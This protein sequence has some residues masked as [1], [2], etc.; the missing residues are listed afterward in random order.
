[1]EKQKLSSILAKESQ[2]QTRSLFLQSRYT[3]GEDRKCAKTNREPTD[4]MF[5]H[6]RSR[7]WH[8]RDRGDCAIG[9]ELFLLS[10]Y[11]RVSIDKVARGRWSC[12][13]RG[14]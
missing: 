12:R 3:L 11:D 4:A 1:M 5:L 2:G 14:A 13:T 10:G 8:G 6:Q 9:D 7:K